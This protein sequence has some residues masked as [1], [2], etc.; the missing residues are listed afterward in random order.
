[1]DD[2]AVVRGGECIGDLY[3]DQQRRLQFE[4][5]AGDELTNVLAFDELHRDEVSAVDFVEIED[6]SDVWVIQRRCETR[7]A[8]KSFEVR[9]LRAELRRYHLDHNR[10]T[11]LD[12]SGFVDRALPADTEL[13]SD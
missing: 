8:F 7:F 1:M 12:V 4:W 13:V 10:P 6:G 3:A 11:E 2:A 5:T 9:F